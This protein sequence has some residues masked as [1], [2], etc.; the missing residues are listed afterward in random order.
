MGERLE[1]GTVIATGPECGI[2]MSEGQRE[3][4]ARRMGIVTGPEPSQLERDLRDALVALVNVVRMQGDSALVNR[5]MVIESL[6]WIVGGAALWGLLAA[7][8]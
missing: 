1:G 2:E 6:I 5:R 7:L 8:L 4:V 3:S